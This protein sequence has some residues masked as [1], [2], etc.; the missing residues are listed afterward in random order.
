MRGRLALLALVWAAPAVAHADSLTVTDQ[1][2]TLSNPAAATIAQSAAGPALPGGGSNNSATSQRGSG[3]S[4]RIEQQNY[5][6]LALTTQ[7]GDGNQSAVQQFGSNGFVS[8]TQ[9]GNGLGITVTQ[10]GN[11]PSITITQTRPGR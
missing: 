1:V 2:A 7:V 11:A 3:N 8:N 9:T 4:A 6:N 10:T 5:G